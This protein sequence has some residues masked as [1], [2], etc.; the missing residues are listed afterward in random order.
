[1]SDPHSRL[2]DSCAKLIRTINH[3]LPADQQ[4]R[5]RD[6]SETPSQWVERAANHLMGRRF[7]TRG[8]R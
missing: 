4:I 5:Q 2:H 7:A 8:N 6:N 3:C 1:M